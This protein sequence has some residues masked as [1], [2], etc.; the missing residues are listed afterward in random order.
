MKVEN[1]QF[2]SN[3]SIID[4]VEMEQAIESG[5]NYLHSHQYPYGEFCSYYSSDPTMAEWCVPQPVTFPTA[6]IVNSL[7]RVKNNP[8]VK[9][10]FKKATGFFQYQSMRGGAMNYFTNWYQYFSLNP[11]D[12]DDTVYIGNFLRGQGAEYVDPTPLLLENRA[13][14]G[15]FYTWFT[16]RLNS[17][18]LLRRLNKEY[19]LLI[20][21]E[22]KKPIGTFI[23]WRR[24]ECS[25]SDIDGVV[26]A[27]VLYYLGKRQETKPII[28]YLLNILENNKE[29]DC[30]KWYR[31]P[32]TFYY[33]YSRNIKK[34][35]TELAHGAQH[36]KSRI[37]KKQK[38]NGKIGNSIL[39]TAMST[40]A[41]INI[42]YEGREVEMAINFII[43]NQSPTGEWPRHILYFSGPKKQIGW[44]SEE[45]TTGF[46]IEA[47][48]SYLNYQEEINHEH[49]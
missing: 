44:G 16:F 6:L 2:S 13:N 34:G 33:F 40:I 47:L 9:D 21:R 43:K 1:C 24:F 28:N 31:D 36:I 20:M 37:L 4:E 27:N 26:N 30:D 15:L 45:L 32:F 12:V 10:I 49:R 3:Y 25:R 14:N 46:C 5:I 11:P 35:I 7:Q 39:E 8:L 17:L 41:L 23:F 29:A 22:L 38:T 42:G 48:A 19:W 18:R